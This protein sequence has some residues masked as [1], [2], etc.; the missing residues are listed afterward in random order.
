MY[1]KLF[2]FH[3]INRFLPRIRNENRW[4]SKI[5]TDFK[6]RIACSSTR[7]G[8]PKIVVDD[9][10]VRSAEIRD[11]KTSTGGRFVLVQY[12]HRRTGNSASVTG[13]TGLQVTV[14]FK[15]HAYIFTKI[16]IRTYSARQKN[17][18]RSIFVAYVL[19][20]ERVRGR[21]YFLVAY[22]THHECTLPRASPYTEI[23]GDVSIRLVL[24]VNAFTRDNNNRTITI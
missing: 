2:A 8:T 22:R 5:R 23:I 6:I 16:K 1:E 3:I 14:A 7:Y 12:L 19:I 10:S 15:S 9:F 20:T 18:T 13:C 11:Y 17:Q 4:T 24:F 21:F